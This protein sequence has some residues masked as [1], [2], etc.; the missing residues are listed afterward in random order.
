MKTV[1]PARTL[2]VV[3]HPDLQRSRIHR[4]WVDTLTSETDATVHPL[5]ERYTHGTIDRSH[6]QALLLAHE[7]VI[8]QFPFYWYST[9]PLV[10]EWL[11]T[12]L[13][14]GWAYGPG[15]RQLHGKEFGVAVSTGSKA[16]DYKADGRYAATMDDLT[17]PFRVLATH[18]GMSYL[19]GFYLNDVRAVSDEQ[20]LVAARE[21]CRH[22]TLPCR[23]RDAQ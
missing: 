4:A 6:E 5:Y 15:G 19:P 1:L 11:D 2:V 9:P 8:L 3:G 23:R 14:R 10:K 18:V 20:L 16:E 12:V 13:E 7:R 21:Y 22:L 17:A